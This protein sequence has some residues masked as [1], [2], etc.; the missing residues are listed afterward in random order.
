[1]S[2]LSVL[3]KKKYLTNHHLMYACLCPDGGGS[4]GVLR[5]LIFL[6]HMAVL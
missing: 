2:S 6:A 3:Y 4:G 1:M 5:P